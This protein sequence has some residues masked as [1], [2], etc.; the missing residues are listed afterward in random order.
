[1]PQLTTARRTAILFTMTV[2][3][4]TYVTTIT[5]ANVAL[6]E[7][8]GAFAA[9]QDQITWVVTSFLLATAVATPMSGWLDAR[10]GRR[11]VLLVSAVAFAFA[12]ALC[13]L[14][15]SLEQLVV[16]RA[17]QGFSG[18]PLLPLGQAI[19]LE[20]YPK[21]QHGRVVL[22]WSVGVTIG[23][24][25]APIAGAYV[26]EEY[27]WRW[28]FLMVVPVAIGCVAMIWFVVKPAVVA[29]GKRG[30]DWIGFFF[31]AIAIS[32]FQLMLDRGERQ[33]WFASPEIV[34]EAVIAGVAVYLFVVHVLTTD[35]PFLDLRLLRDRNYSVGIL[36][37]IVFGMLYFTTLVLQP[38]MLQ[39]LRGYPTAE[40]GLLQATRGIGLLGGT[41]FMLLFL[42]RVD[43]RLSLFAGFMAQAV[44]GFAMAGFDINMTT[45]AVAWTTM[46][47]GFGL[48]L[49]WSPITVVTF[50][51][52]APRHLPE[53]ASVFH[54]LRNIGS[55]VHIAISATIVIRTARVNY[56]ELM[57][58]LNPF[59][60]ALRYGTVMGGWDA[61]SP[62]GL[63]ALS[64]EIARQS[65]M[66]GYLNAYYAYGV[67]AMA[68][69]PLVFLARRPRPAQ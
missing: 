47:Q 49:I 24:I 30:L 41:F 65:A 48:G 57:E 43:P 19:I 68:V 62:A 22:L 54:L 33:D 28:V 64:G 3:V 45:W 69:A 59:N 18:A 7:I 66:I 17:I 55:S 32:A 35:R 5:L 26:T 42:Q 31:L 56:A 34:L 60:E 1:M 51:T 11:R 16:F 15:G 23:T 25:I 58:L 6:P 12:T 29:I 2:T 14:A 10:F 52:L 36:L 20:I 61:A 40:I 46:L 44:A 9:T 39:D 8:Q 13:G 27:S 21:E 50:A 63:A 67:M 4:G 37:G 53:G 38:T